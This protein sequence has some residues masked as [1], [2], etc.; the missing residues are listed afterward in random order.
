LLSKVQQI[1]SNEDCG[2]SVGEEGKGC[3]CQHN[4]LQLMVL[5]Q[6]A[7]STIGE[8]KHLFILWLRNTDIKDNLEQKKCRP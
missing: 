2:I 7:L 6:T 5:G 3:T 8:L 1:H 4:H